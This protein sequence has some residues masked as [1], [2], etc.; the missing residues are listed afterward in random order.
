MNRTARVGQ[1]NEDSTLPSRANIAPMTAALT[2]PWTEEQFLTWAATREGRHEFDGCRPVAMMGSTARHS[3]ITLNTHVALRSRLRGTP[4]SSFGPD[5]GVRTIGGAIRYPDALVTCSRF[6]E[7]ERLA[8][9][10]RVVFEVL[11]ADSGRRDRIEKVR[12]YAAVP[13]I[14]HYIILESASVGLLVL[15]RQQ[16][17]DAWTALTLTGDDTLTLPE[18]GVAIPVEEFYEDVEFD[19]TT[20]GG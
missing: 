14:R 11:S 10:V 3:R 19:D 16:G 13:S 4:C 12:Q 18:I 17:G 15:H 5:L 20:A 2:N 7:S 8:P 1:K 6:P 9:D